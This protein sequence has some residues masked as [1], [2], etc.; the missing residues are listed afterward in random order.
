MDPAP[1]GGTLPFRDGVGP[2]RRKRAPSPPL[3]S[4]DTPAGFAAHREWE[5]VLADARLSVVS[6]PRALGGHA[7][8]LAEWVVFEEEYFAASAPLRVSQN[9]IFLLAPTL[10]AHGTPE[11]LERLLP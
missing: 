2:S 9:G 11:Q 7:A 3:P 10:F 4:M 8:S 5:H 1:A 6:W